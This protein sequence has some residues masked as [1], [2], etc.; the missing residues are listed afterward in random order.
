[1]IFSGMSIEHR[2][3]LFVVKILSVYNN[4]RSKSFSEKIKTRIGWITMV[5]T[6]DIA[7]IGAGAAGL[8]CAF[9]AAGFSKN[10]VL[11]DKN[12]PGGECTWSG[13]IP[14]KTLISIAKEVHHAKKYVP[15]LQ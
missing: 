2:F 7:I 9:T 12:L 11:I 14:S 1:Y 10:V 5:K 3:H 15:G 6:Y 8:T 4:R 13:C